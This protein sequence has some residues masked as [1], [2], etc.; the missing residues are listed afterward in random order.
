MANLVSERIRRVL[1]PKS[2][3][4]EGHQDAVSPHLTL[5]GIVD[6]GVVQSDIGVLIF[7]FASVARS[8]LVYS[9]VDALGSEI[10]PVRRVWKIRDIREDLYGCDG[11]WGGTELVGSSSV[12]I[13][14]KP[15]NNDGSWQLEG[16][17]F[18]TQ[19]ETPL[20]LMARVSLLVLATF[21]VPA[22]CPG[23]RQASRR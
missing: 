16:C 1:L 17:P 8:R 15:S 22:G 9:L 19:T 3:R 7:E 13:P 6:R 20:R 12:M 21:P 5:S 14:V 10:F 4:L 11:R 2:N 18:T 23:R